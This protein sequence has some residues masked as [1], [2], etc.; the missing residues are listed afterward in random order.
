[1][2]KKINCYKTDFSALFILDR[3]FRMERQS[4]EVS[5]GVPVMAQW[6]TNLTRNHEVA[7]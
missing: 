5:S 4:T 2:R 6:L 7:G 3:K 1:M